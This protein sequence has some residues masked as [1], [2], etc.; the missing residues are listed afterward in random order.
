MDSDRSPGLLAEHSDGE[1][2]VALVVPTPGFYLEPDESVHPALSP[3][4]RSRWRGLLSIVEGG[5]YTFRS[6]GA[7]MEL[8]GVELLD[9]PIE[10]AAGSYPLRVIYERREG[11]AS[12]QLRWS[13]E[14]FVEEPIPS[15]AFS[16]RTSDEPADSSRVEE[17]RRLFARLGC[18]GCHDAESSSL[19]SRA[20]PDLSGIGERASARWIYE[21]LTDPGRFRADAVMPAMLDPVDRRDVALYLAGLRRATSPASVRLKSDDAQRGE[22]LYGAIGCAACHTDDDLPLVGMGSKTTAPALMEYLLDPAKMDPHGPMPSLQLTRSEA[23]QLAAHLLESRNALFEREIPEVEAG[24]P[25]RGKRLVET[26]G[27]LSC[28]RLQPARANIAHAPR[29]V[30]LRREDRGCLSP[31]PPSTLPRYWLSVDDREVLGAFIRFYATAPDRSPA[32]VYETRERLQALRC[33]ACHQLDAA[34]PSRSLSERV[35][36]LTGAG[37]K[38][39]VSWLTA[40]LTEKLRVRPDLRLRMPH[41]A[42][43]QV[44]GL[45]RGLAALC[46]VGPEPDGEPPEGG[47]VDAPE[48]LGAKGVH[49]LGTDGEHGGL[50]CI[51]CHDFDKHRPLV[52]EKGPELRS[53]AR[54]VRFDW[55]RRWM[56]APSRILSGTSMP[57][58]F[59]GTPLGQA[60]QVIDELWAAFSLG[61][62]MPLPHGVGSPLTSTTHEVLP[63]PREEPVVLRFILPDATAAAVAVGLPHQG[64]GEGISYCF[65]ATQSRMVYAWEGG[66]ID[67]TDSITKPMRSAR[68]LGDVFYRARDP[69]WRSGTVDHI[70]DSRFRGYRLRKDAP[71]FFYD[72]DGIRVTERIVPTESGTGFRQEFLLARVEQPL[73]FVVDLAQKVALSC[74]LGPVDGG[75]VRVP[76]GEDVRFSLT[77]L[78]TNST[79]EATE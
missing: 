42:S 19:R 70:A 7:R 77:V 28:H 72:V 35:P 8:D 14:E 34:E 64:A 39:R 12:L 44:A 79:A 30:D 60:D 36:P 18:G 5:L 17:G 66:F 65:D 45:P 40:V 31:F 41:F 10:L 75:A 1:R 11:A 2:K 50:S 63:V 9:Q 62:S 67:L 56:L 52:D 6:A 21:W 33:V 74:T 51:A 71:E 57:N 69:L 55:F 25:A 26:S 4:F 73:W 38:L 76:P 68:L 47:E 22:K 23:R 15:S 49:R 3:S 37:D 43:A 54:R 27:C 48:A 58:Y 16:H 32:P 59:T 29:L 61:E 13:S 24:N 20:G 78:R 53:T 46:G